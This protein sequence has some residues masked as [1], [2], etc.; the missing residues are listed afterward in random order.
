MILFYTSSTS[1]P[2]TG[3]PKWKLF[4]SKLHALPFLTAWTLITSKLIFLR[5]KLSM[6]IVLLVCVTEYE[7]LKCNNSRIQTCLTK[8]T[9]VFLVFFFLHR[10]F[11]FTVGCRMSQFT[12]RPACFE[13]QVPKKIPIPALSMY[14]NNPMQAISAKKSY[15][16][17]FSVPRA[18][19]YS[20]QVYGIM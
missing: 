4:F 6:L 10:N 13:T 7:Y 9:L 12:A 2:P 3:V 20:I 11:I 5:I 16:Q 1:W 15:Y 14:N 18:L 8:M 17:H 19:G